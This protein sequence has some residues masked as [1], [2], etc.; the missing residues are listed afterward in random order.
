MIGGKYAPL[1]D[2]T[3]EAAID[4]SRPKAANPARDAER[5]QCVVESGYVRLSVSGAVPCKRRLAFELILVVRGEAYAL[6]PKLG[7]TPAAT[8]CQSPY[9]IQNNL[10]PVAA[11]AATSLAAHPLW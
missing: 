4:A 8:L 1:P 3:S 10:L 9:A 6:T 2:L 11:N 7:Q 5:L